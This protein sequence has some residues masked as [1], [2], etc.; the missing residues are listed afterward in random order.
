MDKRANGLTAFSR[1][2]YI[3]ESYQKKMILKFCLL[4]VAGSAA[5][6]TQGILIK[7]AMVAGN[8]IIDEAKIGGITPAML[9]FRGR[10]DVCAPKVCRPTARFA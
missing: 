1:H 6:C 4:A 2:Y 9:I 10:C 5:F 3:G 7:F 8:M